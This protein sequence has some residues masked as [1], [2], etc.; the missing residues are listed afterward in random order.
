MYLVYV[1][2]CVCVCVCVYL[3]NHI[4]GHI[5]TQKWAKLDE[6]SHHPFKEVLICENKV[7]L[8]KV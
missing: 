6:I 5:C 8:Q 3:L 2:L 1:C 4:L 7:I